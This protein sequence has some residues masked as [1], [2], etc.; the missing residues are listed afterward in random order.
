[1]FPRIKEIAGFLQHYDF[2]AKHAQRVFQ[3]NRPTAAGNC[4]SGVNPR[5]SDATVRNLAVRVKGSTRDG[6]P[7][8][9]YR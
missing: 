9:A 7:I 2:S 6:Q 1:V 3:Q 5:Q 4:T 8:F